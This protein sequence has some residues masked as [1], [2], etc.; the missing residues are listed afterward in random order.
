MG[1][2]APGHTAGPAALPGIR[3]GPV[4]GT[5]TPGIRASIV[6]GPPTEPPVIIQ[7]ADATHHAAAITSPPA[8]IAALP[9]TPSIRPTGR[10]RAADRRAPEA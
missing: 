1:R 3:T 2:T 8:A 9:A 7:S 5:S 10:E 4:G 6:A